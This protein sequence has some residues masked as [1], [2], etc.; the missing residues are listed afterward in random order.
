MPMLECPGVFTIPLVPDGWTATSE[1]SNT[2]FELQPATR[3]AAVHISVYDRSE[4]AVPEHGEAEGFL[5]R[6]VQRGPT[7]GEVKVI[8]VPQEGE[9][10]RAFAKFFKR[11]DRGSLYEWFAGCILWSK[12]MLIC[13]CNAPP[14]HPAL[15]QGEEM[16]ASIFAGTV[17]DA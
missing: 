7:E 11:D 13:T 4:P 16:I 6:V 5:M 10:Q 3:D 14:G 2:F 8:V 17:T 12:T 15:K 1:H 9:E